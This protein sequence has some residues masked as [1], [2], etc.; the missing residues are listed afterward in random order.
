MKIGRIIIVLILIALVA[1]NRL[2]GQPEHSSQE[3]RG[4][5]G[6]PGDDRS[7]RDH[8]AA[9]Q[10]S[11]IRSIPRAICRPDAEMSIFSKVPARSP[12]N[13]VKMASVVSPGQVVSIVNRDEVRVR[14]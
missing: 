8:G 5:Q 1:F 2:P 3:A 10:E 4:G 6:R 13:L 14:L 11:R 9:S 7:G 12:T